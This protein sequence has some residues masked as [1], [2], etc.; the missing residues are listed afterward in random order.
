M[1]KNLTSKTNKLYSL[2]T[3]K[4][5]YSSF[6]ACQTVE[7]LALIVYIFSF[8]INM[9]N[10][11]IYWNQSHLFLVKNTQRKL[12]QYVHFKSQVGWLASQWEGVPARHCR[13]ASAFRSRLGKQFA[14]TQKFAPTLA[15]TQ[16]FAPTARLRAY[17]K[18]SRLR[19]GVGANSCVGA[20][21]RLRK[22]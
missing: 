18:T 12:W 4:K 8:N 1:S 7:E 11:C 10:N 17:S 21:W 13:E 3:L 14:P 16:D 2:R 9:P 19:G 5:P 22:L 6:C 20:S 15:P